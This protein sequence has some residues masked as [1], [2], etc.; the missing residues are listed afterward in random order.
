MLNKFNQQLAGCI[1]TAAY[2][3][4]VTGN[5]PVVVCHGTA[6]QCKDMDEAQAKAESLAHSSG[7][8]VFILKPVKKVSP[9]RDVTTTDLA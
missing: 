7:A 4:P 9:K 1:S 5:G 2:P 3:A 6:V 8:D